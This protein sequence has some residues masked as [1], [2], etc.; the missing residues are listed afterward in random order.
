MESLL[1][2]GFVIVIVGALATQIFK[3]LQE[4]ERGVIFFLGRF[5]TVKGPGL[6]ILIP[7]LQRMTKVDLR[8]IVLDVPTQDVISRDNVS[9]RVN[10]VIYFRI[11]DPEKAIIRVA[12]VF[13]ATSQLS[14]T[15]LRSVLGQHDL[16]FVPLPH[17]GKIVGQ[18]TQAA[19]HEVAKQQ[20]AWVD[21]RCGEGDDEQ[22]VIFSGDLGADETPLLAPPDQPEGCDVLV[23]ESTYGDR[24]HR[25]W[26]ETWQ[27]MGEVF[28]KAQ[29]E[30]GNILIPAFA[31]GRTQELLYTFK[32]HFEEWN[33]GDW[34]IF[35]DSPM[36]IESTKVY[37]KHSKIYDLDA[38][39][40]KQENGSIFD[41]PNLHMTSSTEQSLKINQVKSGAIIIAGSGMCTGGRIKHHFD[42]NIWRDHAHV[43]IVGF[44]ARGTLGR[45]LVDGIDR[46]SLWKKSVP[47]RAG[48]HTIG[49]LSAHADQQGLINWFQHFKNKPEDATLYSALAQLAFNSQDFD[50]AE[51]A[52]TKA[53]DLKPSNDDNALYAKLLEK[54]HDFEK[55]NKVY[56]GLLN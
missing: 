56:Q 9:V 25:N 22:R 52:V 16:T 32:R 47:V 18:V 35:L 5:Q 29:S 36:A 54:S 28:N 50:L 8:V 21:C 48:I 44:Q 17:S 49:G 15:T 37:A 19:S 41:L 43:I 40:A 6:I 30:K 39:E 20:P 34:D 23:M 3:I 13:E 33:I 12:N 24:L 10:A 31:V 55:A 26:S 4:Y 27:E 7:F 53:L 14:Q 38:S 42:H 11:V 46:I 1:P 45:K 2:L 51:K